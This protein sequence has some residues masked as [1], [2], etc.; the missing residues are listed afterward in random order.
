[1]RAVSI[2]EG[3][4]NRGR[5]TSSGG[6]FVLRLF[7]RGV[8]LTANR[9][10]CGRGCTWVGPLPLTARRT[11]NQSDARVCAVDAGGRNLPRSA[12]QRTLN[13]GS[14]ARRRFRVGETDIRLQASFRYEPSR[15]S[16]CC[17]A[18][19][20]KHFR[21]VKTSAALAFSLPRYYGVHELLQ[22]QR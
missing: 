1:M 4:Q 12:L 13:S 9:A 6:R 18:P 15:P 3:E 21:P 7:W 19:Q 20:R 11:I 10:R 14:T 5:F 22:R 16:Y 2:T 8:V 17:R